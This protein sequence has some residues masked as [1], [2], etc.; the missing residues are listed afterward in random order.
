M[1]DDDDFHFAQKVSF[2][3]MNFEL[4]LFI[5]MYIQA[6]SIEF[7]VEVFIYCISAFNYFLDD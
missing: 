1:D 6:E 4:N 2:V 5:L 7:C 3:E